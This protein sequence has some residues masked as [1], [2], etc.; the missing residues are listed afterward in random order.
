MSQ[1]K[2]TL[3]QGSGVHS[4]WAFYAAKY[5][6]TKLL[7]EITYAHY[8]LSQTFVKKSNLANTHLYYICGTWLLAGFVEMCVARS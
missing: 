2:P 1:A 6:I 7:L 5:S 3:L 8:K 4:P